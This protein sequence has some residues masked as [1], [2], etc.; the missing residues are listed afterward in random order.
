MSEFDQKERLE[1]VTVIGREFRPNIAMAILSLRCDSW[2]NKSYL[3][4]HR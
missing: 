3:Q 4:G 2:F 1:A